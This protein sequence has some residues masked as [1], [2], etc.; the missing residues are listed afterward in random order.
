MSS[1]KVS[2]PIDRSACYLYSEDENE[3]SV[4]DSCSRVPSYLLEGLLAGQYYL[5]PEHILKHQS[6]WG[7]RVR[8]DRLVELDCKWQAVES[9]HSK[10]LTDAKDLTAPFKSVEYISVDRTFRCK[11]SQE[12]YCGTFRVYR[13]RLKEHIYRSWTKDLVNDAL[14]DSKSSE[15]NIN[16]SNAG[17]FHS[18]PNFFQKNTEITKEISYAVTAGLQVVE[19]HDCAICIANQ[20]DDAAPRINSK[21]ITPDNCFSYC[22]TRNFEETYSAEAW[23]NVSTHGSWNR[24]HTHEGAAWSGVYY[25]H[26]DPSA[27]CPTRPYSGDLLLKPSPHTTEQTYELSSYEFVRLNARK[28]RNASPMKSG[29][30]DIP[31]NEHAHNVSD[32][33]PVV[34]KYV[35]EKTQPCTGWNTLPFSDACSTESDDEVEEFPRSRPNVQTETDDSAIDPS[36][37]CEYI[38]LSAEEGTLLFFPSYLH[39][40]VVPLAIQKDLRDSVRGARIS[41]AFNFNEQVNV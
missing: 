25:V 7:R 3:R 1:N 30:L 28:A 20:L 31:D 26:S 17:G 2:A 9:K 5:P 33:I 35:S 22:D 16:V 21:G 10:R 27:A 15:N 11:Y 8:Y 18:Q 38:R 41:L 24:L 23:L 32:C 13:L 12:D 40:A 29:T 39:H 4:S 19:H 36:R 34:K 6:G 14:C 37:V